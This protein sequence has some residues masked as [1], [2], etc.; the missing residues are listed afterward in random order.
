MPDLVASQRGMSWETGKAEA[1]G[2]RSSRLAAPATAQNPVYVHCGMARPTSRQ[3][4]S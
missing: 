1:S 4:P 3:V 2:S